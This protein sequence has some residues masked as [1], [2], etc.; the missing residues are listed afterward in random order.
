MAWFNKLERKKNQVVRG[1]ATF[2]QEK[3][4]YLKK[5][6]QKSKLLTVDELQYVL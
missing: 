2:F 5:I 3:L 4:D 6:E 1:N